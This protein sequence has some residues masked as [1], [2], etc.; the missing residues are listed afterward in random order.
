MN[1]AVIKITPEAKDNQVDIQTNGVSKLVVLD[2]L[3][4]C[5]EV[6]AKQ[7]V[8]EARQHVGDDPKAQEKWIDQM[9]QNPN[10]N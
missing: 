9:R 5:M 6:L 2:F 1:T 10:L 7:I 4:G 3:K 8:E